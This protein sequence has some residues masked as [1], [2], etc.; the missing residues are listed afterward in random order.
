MTRTSGTG[1]RASGTGL[2]AGVF[3]D[4]IYAQC[5][6]DPAMDREAFHIGPQDTVFT[7][8]SGGC[9]ALAFLI[10]NPKEVIALDLNPRQNHL[11]DLKMRA[12][13][14]LT[15]DE[16]LEFVGV[17]PSAGRIVMY[18]GLRNTLRRESRLFWDAHRH[19]IAQGIL[20]A[21]RYEHYMAL[22]RRW[23]LRI[24]RG[25]VIDDLFAARSAA[26]RSEIYR[27]RWDTGLWRLF[28][29]VFLSRTV[30][31]RLF[32]DEFFRFVEGSFSFGAHFASRVERALTDE[33]LGDNYFMAYILLGRY[34]SEDHLPPYLQRE[35]YGAIR[36]RLERVR[37]ITDSCGSYFARCVPCSIDKFNFTNIFEWMS[38]ED[39]EQLLRE[40]WRVGTS[41]AVI[42]YRNLLV[43]RERPPA[44]AS[45]LR[46]NR[47]LAA[48]LLARD[49]SFVYRNYVVET[50]RKENV[51]W[52]MKS[53]RSV[54]AA[55]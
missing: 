28:T 1:L 55:S 12:F 45:L 47:E 8:T 4:I 27:T 29:R 6:E 31:G 25:P 3:D 38:P 23:L 39:F 41:A 42:T 15:Y 9:N 51:P 36:S 46:Q 30:M 7:I 5:W 34:L 21:G 2:R 37:L 53:A 49:R 48:S 19:D 26:E 54:A 11:L 50:V 18:E 35:H 52:H 43:F 40:T 13:S 17:R 33:S 24:G 44:L 32:T 10:D 22:L 16:L 20:H 14:A